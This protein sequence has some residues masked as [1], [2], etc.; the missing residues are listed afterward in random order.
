MTTDHYKAGDIECVDYLYD[1]MPLEAFMGGLE[2]NVK[3]YLHR[4]RRKGNPVKDLKKARDYLN[5]L[6][7]VMEGNDP[8]FKEFE[9]EQGVEFD[10][11][12]WDIRFEFTDDNPVSF[13]YNEQTDEST[14]K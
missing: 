4:W 1:N 3:K 13:T 9:Q 7:D 12:A 14:E 8:K 2:W 6:I 11:D 5:V 10:V